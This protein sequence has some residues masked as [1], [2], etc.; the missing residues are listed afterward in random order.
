MQF[1]EWY[2]KSNI[3]KVKYIKKSVAFF[4]HEFDAIIIPPFEVSNMVNR[5]TRNITRK[6]VHKML[7]WAH[8]QFRQRLVAKAEELGVHVIIQNEAYTSKTCSCC[9]SVQKI[10]EVVGL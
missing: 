5:K 8:Y 1:L 10:A 9:G 3:C 6:T 4:T 2:E 7:C